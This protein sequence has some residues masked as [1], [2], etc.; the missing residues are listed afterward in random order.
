MLNQE[1]FMIINATPNE[2]KMKEFQE[3]NTKI[4]PVFMSAGAEPIGRYKTIAKLKGE[5]FPSAVAVLKFKNEE[6]V[7]TVMASKEFNALAGLRAE[8]FASLNIMI[9]VTF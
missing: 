4:M 3:Y 8:V 6:T 1:V 5:N 7:K 9:S 2:N